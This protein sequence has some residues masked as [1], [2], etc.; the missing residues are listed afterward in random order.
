MPSEIHFDTPQGICQAGLARGDI[1]PPVGIYHR[2]WGAASHDRSTGVHRPLTA[3]ALALHP[4]AGEPLAG[5]EA[6]GGLV[7]LAV[8]HCLLWTE[9]TAE[10]LEQV[11][12]AAGVPRDR[13]LVMFSHTHSAG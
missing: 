4:A 2:M 13:L 8:D 11:S 1:T 9:E 5:Q 12:A 3:T 10:L 7:L 6:D